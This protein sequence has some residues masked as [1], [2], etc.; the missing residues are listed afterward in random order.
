MLEFTAF[1]AT[2]TADMLVFTEFP[3]AEKKTKTRS[4][5]SRRKIS[6]FLESQ[7][8]PKFPKNIECECWYLEHFVVE[9]VMF[10]QRNL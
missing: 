5:K 3:V 9:N 10:F 2:V 7:R 1:S 8:K 6:V 4:A